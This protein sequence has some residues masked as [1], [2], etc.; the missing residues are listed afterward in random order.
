MGMHLTWFGSNSWLIEI[1]NQRILLDP[2]LVGPLVFANQSWFFRAEQANPFEIPLNIDL[3]L[4]SQGLPDHAHPP[5]L[6]ALDKTIPVWGS[7]NAIKVVTQLGF[8]NT[9]VLTH[10]Q[11]AQRDNLTIHSFPGSPIGPMLTENAYVI[12]DQAM[13]ESLYY[14]PHGF[15]SPELKEFGSIDAA[16]VPLIDLT[17]PLLGA[18]IQGGDAALSLAQ[19]IQPKALIPT[20]VGGDVNYSGIL[21]SLLGSKG[22]LES[23]RTRFKQSGLTTQIMD[24]FP[25]GE[26]VEVAFNPME[27][28]R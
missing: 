17:I 12:Q 14:E 6:G 1:A 18:F 3:I 13:S 23:L 22:D 5:T 24:P 21:N 28:N 27:L 25:T 16:L 26:R 7:P 2:W 4:L 20:T 15:H 19:W 10:G 9:Q 11:S 8:E